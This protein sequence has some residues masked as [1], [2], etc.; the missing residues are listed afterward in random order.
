MF[1]FCYNLQTLDLSF[2]N[3]Q[4]VT[5]MNSMLYCCSSLK[6]IDLSSFHLILK[7]LLIWEICFMVVV[8]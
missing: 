2:I 5:N 3:T 7:M 6:N 8:V 1:Y 4:N